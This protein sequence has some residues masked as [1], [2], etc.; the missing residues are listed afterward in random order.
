MPTPAEF[1]GP[2]ARTAA[3]IVHFPKMKFLEGRYIVVDVS[4]QRLYEMEGETVTAKPMKVST[5]AGNSTPIGTFSIVR[6]WAGKHESSLYPG[7]HMWDTLY[8]APKIGIHGTAESLYPKLGTP[9]SHGCVRVRQDQAKHL[10]DKYP[11]GTPVVVQ[12]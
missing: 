7:G 1:I 2:I 10:F 12:V 11:N 6:R 9:D 3:R 8:F 4:E 5:G